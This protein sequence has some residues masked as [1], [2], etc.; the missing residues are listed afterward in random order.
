MNKEINFQYKTLFDPF[1]NYWKETNYITKK[2]M[3]VKIFSKDIDREDRESI[4]RTFY[5]NVH[6]EF[7]EDKLN[8]IEL[9]PEP[10]L[11]NIII[12]V[13]LYL[14]KSFDNSLSFPLEEDEVKLLSKQLNNLKDKRTKKSKMLSRIRITR[15]LFDFPS[16][17][18]QK[19]NIFEKRNKL[20]EIIISSKSIFTPLELLYYHVFVLYQPMENY[21]HVVSEAPYSAFAL[22]LNKNTLY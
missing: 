15:D 2:E 17:E 11:L 7:D 14:N 8:L 21:E 19:T 6:Y 4:L 12:A 18:G 20:K 1:S 16:A 9:M 3:M 22:C 10:P 5:E 13:G